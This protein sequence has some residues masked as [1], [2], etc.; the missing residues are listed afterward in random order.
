ME[1][2]AANIEIA[3]DV[4]NE[5]YLLAKLNE[6]HH[7]IAMNTLLRQVVGDSAESMLGASLESF[8]YPFSL[9]KKR[10]F[11]WR[12]VWEVVQQVGQ[13]EGY[14]QYF[15]SDNQKVTM[16]ATIKQQA[17]A[18]YFI[19]QD[20][21]R[22]VADFVA[23]IAK[24]RDLT[25]M[26]EA[27]DSSSIIAI[28]DANGVMTYVNDKFCDISKYDR[29]ELIG[30]PHSIIRSANNPP[31]LY[32][33]LWKTIMQGKVWSGEVE[34][35][36]KDGS[37]FWMKTTIVP[38][39]NE[40]GQPYQH[41]SIHSDITDRV[42]AENELAKAMYHDFRQT[43]KSLQNCIMKVRRNEQ[44]QIVFILSEGKIAEQ[45]GITTEQVEGKSLLEVFQDRY[46]DIEQYYEQ[47]FAGVGS[48]FEAQYGNRF[49][50]TSLSPVVN[51]GKVIEVVASKI[52]IT[53]RKKAEELIRYMAHYDPLTS[54]PNRMSFTIELQKTIERAE[55]EQNQIAV[56]FID[57]DRFKMI[58]DTMGHSK[59]DELLQQVAQRLHHSLP[60]HG[61]VS[62]QGGDEFTL[63]L[64][65]ADRTGA[66]ELALSITKQLSAPFTLNEVEVYIS[67][68]IGI[69]MYPDDGLLIDQLLKC[70]DA[71]MY[72]AKEEQKSTYCFFNE[73]LHQ[74]ISNRLELER[75]LRRAA[76]LG[77]LEL[78]YQPKVNLSNNHLIGMEALLRWR[79]PV[80]G[81]V[82]P[83]MFIHIA[84]ETN[85]IIPIGEWVLR[86]ACSQMKLW[87]EA[88]I[89]DITVAVNISF[90][91]FSDY[92]FPELVARLLQEI[93]LPPQYLELEITESVAQNAKHAI[94]ALTKI[95]ELGV[96]VSID[97]F[98]TGYSSLSSLSQFPIDR[99]KI[100]QSFVRNLNANNQAI[101]RSIIDIANHMN[102]TVIAEGV[103]TLEQVHFLQ[104]HCCQEAQGYYYSKPL[105]K[106]QAWEYLLHHN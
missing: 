102:I 4:W 12:L 29:S 100:D 26:Q 82:A 91:Q 3:A 96:S 13:W 76:E 92:E 39:L 106:Q 15:T 88:G 104:Q 103:E 48:Q 56:L 69:S 40:D 87:L 78:W 99:L 11:S 80:H 14:V 35:R 21:T 101:I 28:T 9:Q 75:D 68:S 32:E 52:E 25:Y 46:T 2:F 94:C 71:A 31:Q 93:E 98:G 95:K 54:L 105:P 41:V 53:E 23:D 61:Y 81:L 62:R 44:E 86:E 66:A 97:D 74:K 47:A 63:F 10:H 17:S 60:Q 20:R 30:M 16:F 8:F 33:E 7:M 70:A 5:I 58:N 27:F 42:I 22:H 24:M 45:L 79:H 67:P 73:D 89:T 55:Q 65:Y 19:A 59:G 83:G 51:E 36:A 72:Q 18:C 38:F 50:L 49:F 57:L 34:N 64:D 77:E 43:I 37:R 85:L 90:Q 6:Q 84:E 1:P